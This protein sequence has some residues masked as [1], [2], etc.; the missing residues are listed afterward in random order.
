MSDGSFKF[1]SPMKSKARSF[2]PQT[3]SAFGDGFVSIRNHEET[4]L[5]R[6]PLALLSY[7][8]G[9]GAIVSK[10]LLVVLREAEVAAGTVDGAS[11][12]H[13]ANFLSRLAVHK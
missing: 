2:L 3:D 12:D 1:A 11:T 9:K 5:Y 10:S 7:N 6:Y 13:I 4:I 8:P